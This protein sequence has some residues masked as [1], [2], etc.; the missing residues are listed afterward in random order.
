MFKEFLG[1]RNIMSGRVGL[2][3]SL[4]SRDCGSDEAVGFYIRCILSL[5]L[6]AKR[7]V[8]YILGLH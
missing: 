1:G 4:E 3:C 7:K 6:K 5:P 2:K 8:V